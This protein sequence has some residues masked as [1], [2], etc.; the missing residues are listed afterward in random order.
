MSG[1]LA[2]GIGVA[3]RRHS[4]LD[5]RKE[6]DARDSAEYLRTFRGEY[7]GPPAA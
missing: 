6:I 2:Q 7:S 1:G 5:S 3:T 4:P